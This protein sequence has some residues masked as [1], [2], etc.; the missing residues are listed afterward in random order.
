MMQSKRD[1]L[2]RRAPAGDLRPT[3]YGDLPPQHRAIPS[4]RRRTMLAMVS[5][6][7]SDRLLFSIDA[8]NRRDAEAAH[9]SIEIAPFDA[10]HL[11]CPRDVALLRRERPQDVVALELIARLMQR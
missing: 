3:T 2:E 7:E 8:T 9:L 4:A 5:V 1:T 6:A 10:Q 11:G